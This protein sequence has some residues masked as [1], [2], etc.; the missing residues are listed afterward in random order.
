MMLPYLVL[1]FVTLMIFLLLLDLK[2]KKINLRKFLSWTLIWI[3][4]ALIAFFPE[5][6]IFSANLIGIERPKDLP[7]YISIIL[8][9]YLL[10]KVGIKLEKIEQ[11]I[12][13]ITRTIA[14]KG[15]K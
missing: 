13:K 8:L 5:I 3:I 12:T 11:N 1:V 6:V 10:F 14:L 7:I 2:D 4:L 9:F 15:E